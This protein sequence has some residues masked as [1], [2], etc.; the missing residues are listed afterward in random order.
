ML[1]VSQVESGRARSPP[2]FPVP[3]PSVSEESKDKSHLHKEEKQAARKELWQGA[4]FLPGTRGA[5]ERWGWIPLKPHPRLIKPRFPEGGENVV[6][7]NEA[8]VG[9]PARS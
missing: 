3:T 5:L 1:W 6:W 9:V 2:Y 8:S 4:S 7:A